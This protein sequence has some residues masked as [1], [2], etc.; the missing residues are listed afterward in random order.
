MPLIK[1]TTGNIVLRNQ[2]GQVR[3]FHSPRRGGKGNKEVFLDAAAKS[4]PTVGVVNRVGTPHIFPSVPGLNPKVVGQACTQMFEIAEGEI[5][6]LFVDARNNYGRRPTR[7]SVYLRI[8]GGAA[9]RSITFKITDHASAAFN[10]G[11]VEGNF[12]ILTLDEVEAEGVK[13]LPQFKHF[14]SDSAVSKAITSQTELSPEAT[15]ATKVKKI[16]VSDEKGGKREVFVAARP[17]RVL[18]A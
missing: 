7:A 12:D 17:K 9:L 14:C 4:G 10:Q 18:G 16:E 3:A 8:R 2:S 11:E 6:K 13:V 5:I 1:L 15:P